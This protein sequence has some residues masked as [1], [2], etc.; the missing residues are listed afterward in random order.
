MLLATMMAT[1]RICPSKNVW[2]SGFS[3]CNNMLIA[4]TGGDMLIMTLAYA[5]RAN[6]VSY[7]KQH[8][9]LLKQW[10][11]FLVQEALIPSNQISTDDFAG[12]APNQ[13]N[14]A[15]KGIIG[16][17]AMAQIAN[18]TGNSADGQNYSAI[19]HDYISKWQGYAI[20]ST[21]NPPHTT[22][23]YGNGSSYSLLYNLYADKELG[24][25]LVP[26]S[27]YTMQSNFYPTKFQQY[28]VPLDTRHTYTK[29]DW[30]VNTTPDDRRV[31]FDADKPIDLVC[32][33]CLGQ[34]E[35]KVRVHARAVA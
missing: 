23:N 14:L 15:L 29:S 33:H 19:A 11:A 25:D 4:V 5:Q 17:E 13:T 12:P 3:D 9:T 1:P 35:A 22:F 2:S 7:L 30:E 6:D 24:L 16:I 20:D 31:R 32:S 21:A 26:E 34:H 10:T 27:V 18:L 28:G 8:Y